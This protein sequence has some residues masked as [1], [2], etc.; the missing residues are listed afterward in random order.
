MT[1]RQK[2]TPL[3]PPLLSPKPRKRPTAPHVAPTSRPRKPSGWQPHS[4]RG[5]LSRQIQ[6]NMALAMTSTKAE[7][8]E[9]TYSVKG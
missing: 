4:V 7:N 6:G 9:R 8:A 1:S 2:P 5:F 3:S